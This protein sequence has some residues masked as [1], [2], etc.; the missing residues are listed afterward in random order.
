M[1]RA[2]LAARL[3][4]AFLGELEE[5][6]RAWNGEVLALESAPAD[7]ERLRA[8]F[9]IAHTLKG[10]ARAAGVPLIEQSCHALESLL[11][12]ARDQQLALTPTHIQLLFRA[13]DAWSDA[14]ARLRAGSALEGSPVAQLAAHLAAGSPG[15]G[16]AEATAPPAAAVSPAKG[17]NGQVRIQREKLDA[18]LAATGELFL[19][20]SRLSALARE[21]EELQGDV[22]RSRTAWRRG[23]GRVR[24]ALDPTKAPA[25]GQ[26]LEELERALETLSRRIGDL[27]GGARGEAHRVLRTSEEIQQRVRDLR[28]RPFADACEALPRAVRD[29]AQASGK[30]AE[31]TVRGGDVEA[32]RAVLDGLKGPLLQLV[33]NAIDHGVEPPEERRRAGKPPRGRVEVAASL[34][35]DRLVVTVSDDG[36]GLNVAAIREALARRGRAAPPEDREVVRE[37]LAGGVS[38][39][40]EADVVSGRGVGLDVVREAMQRLRGSLDVEWEPGRGTRFVL[41][42]PPSLVTLR[43][44]L[45]AVGPEVVALPTH[46]VERLRRVRPEEVATIEGEPVLPSPHGPLKLV[47]LAALAGWLPAAPPPGPLPV[48]QLAHGGRRLAVAVDQ[49]LGEEELLL[50]PFQATEGGPL[51]SGGAL[52]G[53][54]RIALVLNPEA[55]VTAGLEVPAAGTVPARGSASAPPRRRILVV[56]DSLTTRTLEQS[57][58]EAAGYEVVAAV[59]GAEAWRLL[60]ERGCDLVVADVEMPRMDGFELCRAVRAS[61]RVGKTPVVLVTAMETPEHRARGLEVGADAYLG[62]SSFDQEQLLETIRQLLGEGATAEQARRG[63]ERP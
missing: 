55:I 41:Q 60:N 53:T 15:A 12:Q 61:Q 39:R 10:A 24:L 51:L 48:M 25:A 1:S 30:E 59:D 4:K 21:L 56:D 58:L 22:L 8:V 6:L 27:A 50:R 26:A 16:V 35:G 18:L 63:V 5:H 29:V 42:C 9:R 19:D 57:I 13:A 52:L 20:R 2:P 45:A 47:A 40:R 36:A 38:T 32:D 11:A 3:L 7:A 28:L 54:G 33:R 14:A 37:L 23:L 43:A 34:A 49:F 46:A 44:V 31:L 17:A 62:K